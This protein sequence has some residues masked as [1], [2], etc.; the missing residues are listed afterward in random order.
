MNK[1]RI[2]FFIVIII[3]V[4]FFSSCRSDGPDGVDITGVWQGTVFSNDDENNAEIVVFE[5]LDNGD[6]RMGNPGDIIIYDETWA[7]EF[8]W[9][10]DERYLEITAWFDLYYAEY[11]YNLIDDNTLEIILIQRNFFNDTYEEIRCGDRIVLIKN[12]TD[13]FM[14]LVTADDSEF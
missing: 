10:L 11:Y 13:T 4:V 1:T 9:S 8:T 5:F 2:L 12:E 14:D 6:A 7:V 3:V